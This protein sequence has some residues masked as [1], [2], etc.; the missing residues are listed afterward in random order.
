M[1]VPEVTLVEVFQKKTWW[2]KDLMGTV[3]IK[4]QHEG[5]EPFDFIQIHYD[6]AYT[7]N[8]HQYELTRKVLAALGVDDMEAAYRPSAQ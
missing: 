6:H 8:G 3:H 5:C 4:Q 2:E 7:S 1:N